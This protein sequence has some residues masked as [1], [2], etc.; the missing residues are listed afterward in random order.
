MMIS[1]SF[2]YTATLGFQVLLIG[3]AVGQAVKGGMTAGDCVMVIS[4][5]TLIANQVW[6]L[7]NRMLEFFEQY[8][9]IIDSIELVTR[10]HEIVDRQA[11]ADLKATRGE[12]EIRQA[13]FAPAEAPPVFEGLNLTIVGGEKARLLGPT[14]PGHSTP[15]RLR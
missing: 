13:H 3:I 7:S 2:Q 9:V 4:L 15:A 11:P 10:P 5:S 8:G 12:I 14:A 6:N 1:H